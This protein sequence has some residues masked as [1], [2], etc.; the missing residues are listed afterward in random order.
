MIWVT[1]HLMGAEQMDELIFMENG[2]IAMRGSHEQL[3]AKEERYR[4]LVELDRP[5]WAGN[6]KRE[7]WA[8]TWQKPEPHFN[9]K[10]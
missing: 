5:G 10:M 1:H 2:R 4:R 9:R 7:P 3:L 8:Q 6:A